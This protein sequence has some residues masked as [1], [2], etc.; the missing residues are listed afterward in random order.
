[1]RLEAMTEEDVAIR[2]RMETD[3]RMMAELGGPRPREQVERAHSRAMKRAAEGKAWLL[4]VIPD[5]SGA[6]AGGVLLWESSLLGT[7]VNEIGWMIFPEFQNRGIASQAV[8][9]VLAKARTEGK[10]GQIHAFPGAG[11]GASNAICRKNGFVLVGERD[12]E[13]AGRT[14]RCNHWRVDL[15]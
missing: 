1:M 11:N 12:V 5:G 10:F 9:E 6:V 13:F 2:I 15:F 7:A 8:R 14:L 4:K 3:P